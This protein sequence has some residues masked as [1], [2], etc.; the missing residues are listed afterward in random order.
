MDL[1]QRQ[2]TASDLRAA[3]ANCAQ[4]VLAP[5]DQETGSDRET[6]LAVGAA[7]GAG[8]AGNGEICGVPNAMA[9]ARGMIC[10]RAGKSKAE[11]VADAKQYTEAFRH[12]H[13]ALCCRDL[14]GK[15]GCATCNELIAE[16]V[17]ML[18]NG[19]K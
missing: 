3:G 10:R 19:L 6:L 2:K 12:R 15:P 1:S 11:I 5:F 13:G 8:V 16:G 9:I 4:A 18:H 17:E 7:L 14:K